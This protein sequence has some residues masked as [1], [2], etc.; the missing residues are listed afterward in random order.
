MDHH[1]HNPYIWFVSVDGSPQSNQAFE[2]CFKSFYLPEDKI[3][4]ATI[5]DKSKTYL[6][7]TMAP[8]TI[9]DDYHT[10]LLSHVHSSKYKILLEE[11]QHDVTIKDQILLV[12][13]KY[14]ATVI[15]IGYTGRKGIKAESTVMGSTTR[16]AVI[17][18]KIPLV[19]TKSIVSREKTKT[20]GF[21]FLV[22]LDGSLKAEKGLSVVKKFLRSPHDQVIGCLVEAQENGDKVHEIE[23]HYHA[24]QKETKVQ[25]EFIKLTLSI[26]VADAIIKYV[27]NN[28]Q[29]F[30]DFI[31]LGN[32]GRRSQLEGTTTLGTVAEDLIT[33]ANANIIL[34]P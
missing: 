8:E 32:S 1:H 13:E 2:Q 5:V 30:V 6:P 14:E 28:E 11:K 26:N 3:F 4:V 34:L 12:A 16:H 23:Q 9:Y 31:V 19:I 17:N 22:C 7:H 24:F 25:G 29:H 33:K 18:T 20:K 21:T 15:F 10:F 27:N